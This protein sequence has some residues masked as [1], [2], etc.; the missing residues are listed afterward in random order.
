MSLESLQ[1]ALSQHHGGTTHSAVAKRLVKLVEGDSP[2]QVF[3]EHMLP[4]IVELFEAEA[5]MIWLRAH[6]AQAACFALRFK[7]DGMQWDTKTLKKHDRLVQLAWQQKQPMLVEPQEKKKQGLDPFGQYRI[8]FGPIIHLHE[9]LAVVE[10]LLED[11]KE[12]SPA[13]R[14]SLLKLMQVVMETIHGG[15]QR[16]VRLPAGSMPQAVKVMEQLEQ[17]IESYQLSIQRSIETRLRQFQGWTFGSLAENQQFAK[18]VHKILDEHGL[19]VRCPECGH[20]S[21]LRCLNSGNS[22]HGVFVFDHYL[23]G[24]RTFH[25]GPTTFPAITVIGK[26]ARRANLSAS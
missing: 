8:L 15:L 6:A 9:P 11:T 19:R 24:G 10:V 17:E 1:Q 14:K 23:E 21:I 26:P 7:M 13:H 22:K 25:G 12:L 16:R 4:S 3:L 18:M 2:L 20:A 5:G